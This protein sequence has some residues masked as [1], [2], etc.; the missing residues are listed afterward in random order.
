MITQEQKDILNK[1]AEIKTEIKRLETL[2]EELNPQ[3]LELMQAN[4]L[5][6][7]SVGDMGKL[8]LGSKRTWKYSSRVKE[9]EEKLKEQ[10]TIEEQTGLADYTEK[11]YVLFK[12][13]N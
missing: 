13:N 1:Y 2:S 10:K 11:H 12:R 5:G 7:I 9:L 3:V 4:E 8:S 6:E